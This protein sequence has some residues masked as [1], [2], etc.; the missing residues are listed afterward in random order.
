MLFG[1]DRADSSLRIAVKEGDK[2][3]HLLLTITHQ[4]G[5]NLNASQEPSSRSSGKINDSK[6]VTNVMAA[7]M[8]RALPPA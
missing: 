7:S 2:T 5:V 4:R 3:F 1:I 6:G 8:L